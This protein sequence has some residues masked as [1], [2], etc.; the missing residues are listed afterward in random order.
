MTSLT[1]GIDGKLVSKERP[2]LGK[3]GVYTPKK[4]SVF[5]QI[6]GYA[7]RAASY[8]QRT[9]LPFD[10]PIKVEIS[11]QIYMPLSWSKTRRNESIGKP[12]IARL[13]I[14]N[15]AK[16]LLDGMNM[17]VYRDDSQVTDLIIR[18]VWSAIDRTIVT[19][20]PWVL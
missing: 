13:D 1:F 7:A 9:P 14:D 17:I 6:V 10:G 20:T 19:V 18:R 8:A 2:R 12:A 16:I 15:Q 4:T 11:V 5:E 3:N